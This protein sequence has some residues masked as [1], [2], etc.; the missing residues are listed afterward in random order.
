MTN[1]I[2]RQIKCRLITGRHKQK[3]QVCNQKRKLG[4]CQSEFSK[5]TEVIRYIGKIIVDRFS[6]MDQ[7]GHTIEEFRAEIAK[8]KFELCQTKSKLEEEKQKS[9][10]NSKVRPNQILEYLDEN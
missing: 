8:L 5:F 2:R 10:F 3:T 9:R 4:I 7:A 6:K 1:Q